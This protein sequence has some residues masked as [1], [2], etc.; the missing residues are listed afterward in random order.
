[1]S[2]HD[3]AEGADRSAAAPAPPALFDRHDL[4]RQRKDA[5]FASF[6]RAQLRPLVGFLINQGAGVR[7]AAD[8]AQESM[9][10]AYRRWGDI[11]YPKAWIH[12]A[13]SRALVRKVAHVE[14]LVEEVP[15]PTSLLPRPD[16]IA[17]W[18]VRHD[19]LLILRSLPPRQ[20]QVM[21][22]TLNGFTPTDIADHLGLPAETVRANLKKARRAA[23]ARLKEREED[24]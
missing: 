15:E 24:Q 3:P 16:A 2:V 1:M 6:Y 5:E 12:K 22:W 10:D 20:R 13:A 18:E 17:E 4:L 7:D 9:T 8:I 14:E 21:A 23:A 11:E 19:A